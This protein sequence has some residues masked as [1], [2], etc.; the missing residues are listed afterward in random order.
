MN[1]HIID[2]SKGIKSV[3]IETYRSTSLV[4]QNDDMARITITM[5]IRENMALYNALKYD[6]ID[7]NKCIIDPISSRACEFGTR[8]CI[9]NHDE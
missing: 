7:Q 2:F 8:G 6:H 3:N 9:V 4:N 1:K 5:K